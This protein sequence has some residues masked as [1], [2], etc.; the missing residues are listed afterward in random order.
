[1]GI[2]SPEQLQKLAEIIRKELGNRPAPE[3]SGTVVVET[4]KVEGGR[5]TRFKQSAQA[6]AQSVGNA[7]RSPRAIAE[8]AS[9][10]AQSA[11]ET[12]EQKAASAKMSFKQAYPMLLK[13][14]AP[15]V[16]QSA[17]GQGLQAAL[18]TTGGLLP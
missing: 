2:P 13:Q 14:L 16:A 18:H 15:S 6:A 5:W 9:K 10:A 1:M 7:T 17:L 3:P 12:V 4:P 8:A 11:R